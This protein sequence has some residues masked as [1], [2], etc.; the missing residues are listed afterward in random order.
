MI[1]ISLL[2]CLATFLRSRIKI[3]QTFLVPASLIGGILGF[4]CVNLG[5]VG[6]PTMEGWQPIPTKV[7]SVM[8]FHLF[9][10]GFV[11]VG[12]MKSKETNTSKLMFRGG[13]WMALMYC[14]I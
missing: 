4:I 9:A 13:L 10:F 7:F 1:W 6:M 14:F 3:L 5:I 8:T 11:G 2:L 12:L